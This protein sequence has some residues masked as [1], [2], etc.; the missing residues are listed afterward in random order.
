MENVR[1]VALERGR[2]LGLGFLYW[3]TVLLVLEPGN[4]ARAGGTLVWDQEIARIFGASMLG[5]FSIPLLLALMRWFPIEGGKLWSHATVHSLGSAGISFGLIVL[6][7]IFAA[8]LKIGDSRP[9]LTALPDHLAANWLLLTFCLAA[10][11]A[12]AHAARFFHRAEESRRLIA[13][14]QTSAPPSV[15]KTYLTRVEVK[16]RGHV[17]M[18]DLAEVD[19]IETQG[20]YLALHAASGT[21]LVRDSL[22]SFEAKL[23]PN[24]FVRTHRRMLVPINRIREVTSLTSGDAMIRLSNGAE[25]RLSRSYRDDVRAVLSARV[26]NS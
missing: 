18:V 3:L 21:H 13:Q 16:S 26:Q 15:P 23:D 6:S 20:N 14:L 10:F 22:T 5:A 12:V 8:W 11:T 4:I 7:C 9:F 24:H 17:A 1:W 2:E 19:W 25:L